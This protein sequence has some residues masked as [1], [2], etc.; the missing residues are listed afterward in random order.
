MKI[1]IIGPE[2]P[3]SPGGEAEYAVQVARELSR[4]GHHVVVYSLQGN[5][6]EN[7]NFEVRDVLSGHYLTDRIAIRDIER[8]DIVHILSAGW[9]WIGNV[10][11][12]TF[13]S[14]HG[15]D[16]I[17]PNPVY[18]FDL[19]KRF[20]LPKGDRLDHW[21]AVRRTRSMMKRRL[22]AARRIFANSG[23][24]K[25]VFLQRYPACRG[26]V[27]KV[28]V[29]VASRFFDRPISR[30]ERSNPVRFLTVCRLSE[31]R[32]NVDIVLRAIASLKSEFAFT[33]TIVGEGTLRPQLQAL[34][35][36]LNVADIVNFVGKASDGEL[37]SYYHDSDLF[38]LP[39]SVLRTSFEGFGIVYLE[40]NACGV[41]T[42][43]ARVGGAAEAVDDGVSGFFVEKPDV[44]SVRLCLRA[45]LTGEQKFNA[46]RCRQFAEQFNWAQI[47]DKFERAYEAELEVR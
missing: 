21:L 8:A 1:A 31:P 6:G 14:I 24:T 27:V 19:K 44:D 25:E 35:D 20:R 39:S 38:V 30:T 13:L 16:F 47:V 5:H 7:E 26:L 9:C 11:Q 23:Y 33:Y 45:F 36:Q 4:R 12:P 3:P 32:K 34:A 40:A 42:L 43:A 10:H 41:P 28:G 15:N 17:N 2:F 22:P 37:I 18:G 46:E 29:G